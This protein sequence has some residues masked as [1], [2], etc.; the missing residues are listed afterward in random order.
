MQQTRDRSESAPVA[1]RPWYQD[2]ASALAFFALALAA[3]KAV[4]RAL[5]PIAGLFFLLVT[6]GAGW[7]FAR[8]AWR[9]FLRCRGGR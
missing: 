7:L 5:G 2:A 8:I 4:S 9:E 6:L 3:G 1:R